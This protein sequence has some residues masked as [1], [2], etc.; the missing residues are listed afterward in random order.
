MPRVDIAFQ[1]L[2][3][4]PTVHVGQEDVSVSAAGRYSRVMARATA[5]SEVT[6]PLKLSPAPLEQ[7][8]GKVQVVFPQL[9]EPGVRLNDVAIVANLVES[10]EFPAW[11]RALVLGLAMMCHWFFGWAAAPG[12]ACAA[13]GRQEGLR[14]IQREDVPRPGLLVRR[15]SPP[16]RPRQFRLMA[17]PR[18]VP[19]TA[20]VLPSAAGRL[21]DDVL[22]VG[23]DADASVA[24][25]NASPVRVMRLSF[26]GFTGRSR[27]HG[28]RHLAV[29]REL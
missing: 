1:A 20:V 6:S 7:Q 5:P 16:S 27:R 17:S 11:P 29:M 19:P 8:A 3:H 10:A 12:S 14:E 28:E 26:S 24:T 18:P 25:E 23:G 4:A 9:G 21:E 22:L 15:I 13:V 2:E